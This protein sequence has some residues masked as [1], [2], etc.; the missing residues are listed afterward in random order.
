MLK[1]LS[2][3]TF[4]I[5]MKSGHLRMLNSGTN[6][7]QTS[8]F[9]GNKQQ[10]FTLVIV[11]LL[12]SL[13]SIL[14]LNSL[15]DNVNQERLS[16]N[17]QKKINSRLI[18]ERGIF[19]SI[20]LARDFLAVDQ[21]ATIADLA[22]NLANGTQTFNQND[23]KYEVTAT[24]VS[25]ELLLS[26]IG[27]NFEG[28]S[29]LK[30]R[31]KIVPG[32]G[33]SPFANAVVGCEGVDLAGS[34]QIDSYNSKDAAYDAA[35]PGNEG[36]V[37]T[38]DKSGANVTLGGNSPILGNVNSTGDIHTKS[39]DVD[40][41]LHANG[42]I[43]IGSSSVKLRVSGNILTRGNY[44]QKGGEIGGHVR[45]NG[46]AYMTW[47]N[48]IL[49]SAHNGLDILYGG[50]GTFEDTTNNDF[51]S[52][53]K[54]NVFPNV[55]KVKDSDATA[56][57]YRADDPATNC[58]HLGIENVIDTV[59][60]GSNSLVAFVSSGSGVNYTIEPTKMYISG[61]SAT[62]TSVTA[63]VLGDNIDVIKF[64]AFNLRGSDKVLIKGGD[65]TLFVED[66]F[67]MAGATQLTIEAGSSL[68]LMM[69]GSVELRAGAD[70]IA[71]QH[72]LA[73][74][75]RSLPAMSIYSSYNGSGIN[76]NG[77]F[78]MYAQIYAPLADVSITG[79]G[80]LY[81][82]VRG[83][84]VTVKGGAAIHYDAALGE[85]DR[86]DSYSSQS[87]LAFVGWQY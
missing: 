54:Y 23:M 11:L 46:D 36:D 1:W 7:T 37:S 83:K 31:L 72:G 80:T 68:T 58:D 43:I 4:W 48:Y 79:S 82:A 86:G 70:I 55:A 6:K 49:N 69:K 38:I 66:D 61:N 53:A 28:E 56:S 8:S 71:L 67:T 15:K 45:A 75:P 22:A 27:N 2:V 57:D 73:N 81:G 25:G 47:N 77:N 17:F 52:E 87:R 64:S 30:V 20:A 60:N 59:D 62:F 5:Q 84:T 32:G 44:T 85:S 35:T 9:S 51:Y 74:P 33:G 42:N 40:G 50:S 26:S 12:S 3:N 13:A 34:G 78:K 10:G 16:G 39:S 41:N 65:V 76:I 19:D 63:D 29:S 24:N 18:S 14:V 21:S